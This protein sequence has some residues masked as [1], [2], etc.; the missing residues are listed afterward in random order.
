MGIF[1]HI[2]IKG[3]W[4]VEDLTC[5]RHLFFFVKALALWFCQSTDGTYGC[6]LPTLR[7][8][9]LADPLLQLLT[10]CMN[11]LLPILR[12]VHR[13][14]RSLR[15]PRESPP[16]RHRLESLHLH[17]RHPLRTGIDLKLA[18]LGQ[19]LIVHYLLTVLHGLP[20]L[21]AFLGAA[22]VCLLVVLAVG[23]ECANKVRVVQSFVYVAVIA[24]DVVEEVFLIHIT[25]EIEAF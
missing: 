5:I 14:C 25:T 24:P 15:H 11:A 1:S 2:L 9:W 13:R 17:G 6:T 23:T 4:I 8:L 22:H 19:F 21:L 18:V 10:L 12:C 7:C 20:F 3:V 16:T